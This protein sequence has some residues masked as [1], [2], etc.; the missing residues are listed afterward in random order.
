MT[1]REI[2]FEEQVAVQGSGPFIDFVAGGAGTGGAFGLAVG[3]YGG[4]TLT[5]AATGAAGFAAIGG[6]LAAIGYGS[7]WV[8]S[9]FLEWAFDYK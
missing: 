4:G 6:G 9:K 7:Y 5:A 2:S 1:I 8:T 3:S